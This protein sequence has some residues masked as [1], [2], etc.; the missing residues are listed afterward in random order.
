MR[1]RRLEEG[2]EEE[3]EVLY[4]LRCRLLSFDERRVGGR[5]DRV[6]GFWYVSLGRFLCI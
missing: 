6:S 2:E 5:A 3:K 1:I 4:S